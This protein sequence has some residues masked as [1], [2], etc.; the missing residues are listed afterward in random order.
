MTAKRFSDIGLDQ[1][2]LIPVGGWH[3]PHEKSLESIR[4]LGEK[5]LPQFR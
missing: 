4:I 3:T 1:L 5:V 2:V